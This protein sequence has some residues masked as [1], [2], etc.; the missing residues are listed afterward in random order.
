MT[1][2]PIDCF[3]DE[4]DFLTKHSTFVLTFGSMLSGGIAVILTYFLKSRCTSVQLGCVKCERDPVHLEPNQVEI[5]P[6]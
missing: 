1:L 6:A 2:C 4:D 5:S 3:K